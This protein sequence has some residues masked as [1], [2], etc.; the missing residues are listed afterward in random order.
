MSL[1]DLSRKISREWKTLRDSKKQK[2]VEDYHNKLDEYKE[3]LSD[4]ENTDEYPLYTSLFTRYEEEL[5]TW[6]Q[7]NPEESKSGSNG[8]AG[9]RRWFN[10]L[11]QRG[12][13]LKESMPDQSGADRKRQI[14]SEWKSM[15][16]DEKNQYLHTVVEE[17]VKSPAPKRRRRRRRKVQPPS[18]S[19]VSGDDE[20]DD[21]E[22]EVKSPAP[23]R[24]QRRRKVQPPSPLPVSGDD[25]EDDSGDDSGNDSGN[26]SA[27][28]D[29]W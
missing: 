20:G 8:S 28:P 27:H 5:A 23:K 10:F 26:D 19:P 21:S 1:P 4:F 13:E 11:K 14:S 3:L 22:E 24:R 16:D 25:S 6:K 9:K 15:S 2:L 29:D 7:N 17:E 12:I 18:P